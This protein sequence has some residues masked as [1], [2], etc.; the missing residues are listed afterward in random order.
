MSSDFFRAHRVPG[1]ACLLPPGLLHQGPMNPRL[2]EK[3][4]C[5]ACG[6]ALAASGAEVA[7]CGV[8]GAAYAVLEGVLDL[9]PL[10][11]EAAA[12]EMAAHVTLEQRWLDEVVPQELHP[13]VTGEAGLENLLAMPH[14]PHPE[15]VEAVPDIRRVHEM[16]DDFFELL[17]RL[18]LR[19][20]EHVLEVGSHL[21][22]SA[23]RLAQRTAYVVATDISHQLT[24]AQA[25]IDH[26]P[27]FDRVY[28]DMMALHF[29]PGAFDLVFGVAVAHHA[30][31]LARLFGECRKV[32]RP[33][34]RA[35]FFAE[36]VAG[37]GDE[38]VKET[39]GAAEKAFGV[40]EHIY[41]IDEYFDAARAAGL[42]PSV[43]PLSGVLRERGRKWPWARRV[44]RVLLWT[45]IGYTGVFTRGLYP[46]MLR[47][48]PRIPFP[49][50]AL[51]LAPCG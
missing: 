31:D 8:C 36:P 24:M 39:F 33:G 21:G 44:W 51:V 29:Q 6:G 38:A 16:A 26:G 4:C 11:S 25:F 22:W 45:R 30:D 13:L 41:T 20:D 42:R 15:L 9:N 7:R 28:C 18:R 12:R 27:H 17:D 23:H 19:G 47:R 10:P 14:C 5:P 49:R 35:V 32:L 34:G 43:L 46:C 37:V 1:R 3:V 2:L 48:Y 50:F 40:Q